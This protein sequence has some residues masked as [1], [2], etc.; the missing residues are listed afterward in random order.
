MTQLRES[1]DNPDLG[2][3]SCR[4]FVVPQ[5]NFTCKDYTDMI[6]FDKEVMYEPIFTTGLTREEIEKIKMEKLIVRKFSNNNQGIERLVKQT[7]RACEKV[8]GW[9][10]R[11]GYLRASAKSRSLMPKF[12]SKQDYQNNFE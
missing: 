3:T 1:S 5:I 11:D 12:N 4:K 2:D 7:S 9:A 8:V 10:G 6:D